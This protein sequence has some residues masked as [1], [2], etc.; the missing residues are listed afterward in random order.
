MPLTKTSNVGFRASNA[1]QSIQ[2]FQ[3][4]SQGAQV[5]ASVALGG[6]GALDEGNLRIENERLKTTLMI[7]NQKM[8]TQEDNEDLHDKWKAQCAQK[9]SQVQ[10]L[11]GEIVQLNMT[12][13]MQRLKIKA[14]SKAMADCEGQL[15]AAQ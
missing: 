14:H 2:A 13:E 10:Q 12:N 11:N 8:K 1:L 5:R 9:E 6:S 3:S 7:L 4:Q 15:L